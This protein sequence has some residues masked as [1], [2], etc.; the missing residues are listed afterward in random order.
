MTAPRDAHRTRGITA[1]LGLAA[2][3]GCD[4]GERTAAPAPTP[5]RR[6]L[7]PPQRSGGAALASVLA[8]RRSVREFGARALDDVELGQLMWAAQGVT[9]GHRTAPSAGALYPLTVR[10]IDA[11]GVWRYVPADHAVVREAAG[12]V[13]GEAAEAGY[14][15][16][17]VRSAPV[18]LVISA[19]LAITR[20]KYGAKAGRFATLEA[21]HAA[22]NVLLTA[23]AL[24]LGAVPIGAFDDDDLRRALGLPDD[25]TPLYLIPVGA[26][27]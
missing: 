24:G 17:S 10:V 18:T 14:G 3:V 25:A 23:T 7:P 16:A 27:R 1:A 4:A 13:R 22:Q 2:L 12:D 6:A 9:D 8:A 26:L 20:T 19:E 5:E 15:Q 11:H 21:G